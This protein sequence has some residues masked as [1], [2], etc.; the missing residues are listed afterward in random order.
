[1]TPVYPK[2][3]AYPSRIEVDVELSREFYSSV[4]DGGFIGVVLDKFEH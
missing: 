3:T 2:Q 1:M 4:V